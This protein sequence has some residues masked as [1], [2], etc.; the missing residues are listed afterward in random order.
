MKSNVIMLSILAVITTACN[1]GGG[2][3]G[4]G[5]AP[6][7]NFP[8][9]GCTTITTTGNGGYLSPTIF[10][11]P[12]YTAAGY[13]YMSTFNFPLV[14]YTEMVYPTQTESTI[15]F[16]SSGDPLTQTT[17]GGACSMGTITGNSSYA[18]DVIYYTNCNASVTGQ[19]LTFSAN[20]GIY[21]PTQYPGAGTSLQSGILSFSCTLE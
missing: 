3:G 2:G 4:G 10:S 12:S 14:Q 16:I 17:L 18:S 9:G 1:G 19:Q 11:T 21:L 15:S 8:I 6:V 20:Y 13:H 7:N 5:N